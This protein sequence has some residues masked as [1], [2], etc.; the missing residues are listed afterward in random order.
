MSRYECRELFYKVPLH[1]E[2]SHAVLTIP[3]RQHFHILNLVK[4][5]YLNIWYRILLNFKEYSVSTYCK[6]YITWIL[7]KLNIRKYTPT[8]PKL[9]IMTSSIGKSVPKQQRK[10]IWKSFV[11]LLTISSGTL[12][13]WW[14]FVYFSWP[15]KNICVH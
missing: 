10:R 12:K 3:R 1:D 6:K 15:Q 9:N 5:C 2:W 13:I 14:K 11:Y 7:R 8:E 4:R